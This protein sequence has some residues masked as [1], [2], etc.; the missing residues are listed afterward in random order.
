MTISTDHELLTVAEAAERLRVTTRLCAHLDERVGP[1]KTALL[2]PAPDGRNLSPSIL[3]WYVWPTRQAAGRPDLRFP[4]LR[5]TG[6]VLAAST[7][8]TLA[9]LMA[10]LGHSTPQAAMK[11]QHAAADRDRVI[12][13]ALSKLV[14]DAAAENRGQRR[15]QRE[16]S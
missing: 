11:Y 12:A 16:A 6:A 3:Y 5:H 1:E 13:E 15:A 4:D 9:E 8:A 14:I 7:G 2:F 10:R